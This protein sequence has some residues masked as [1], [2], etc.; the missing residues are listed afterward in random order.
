MGNKVSQEQKQ[1]ITNEVNN[2]IS[3][4]I[5]NINKNITETINST[6]NKTTSNMVIKNAANI[7]SSNSASNSIKT[8]TIE[9]SGNGN[10][11]DVNQKA[12]T[13][14]QLTAAQSISSDIS[15]RQK[16]ASDIKNDLSN[17]I[18]NDNSLKSS[19]S[20]S[21]ALQNLQKDGG[22]IES[23]VNN[24]L[25]SLTSIVGGGGTSTENE[26]KSIINTNIKLHLPYYVR[27]G[28]LIIFK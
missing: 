5:K 21:S 12:S 3:I 25:S 24:V 18:K 9:L 2:N 7:S 6:I 27:K 13:A 23:I 11:I 26:V 28:D 15:Q 8:Q 14:S 4:Q 19:I 22:G 1:Q 16:L 10:T 17:N 20:S